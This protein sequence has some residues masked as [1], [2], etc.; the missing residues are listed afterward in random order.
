MFRADGFWLISERCADVMRKFDLG[1][2]SLCPAKILQKGGAPA[3]PEKF[4]CLNFGNAL[5]D[6]G[7]SVPFS[8]LKKCKVV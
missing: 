7:L 3:L 5:I 2:G 4:Y 1:A 8:D 6:A